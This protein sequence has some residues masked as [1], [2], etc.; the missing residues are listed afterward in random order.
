MAT[1]GEHPTSSR[2]WIPTRFYRTISEFDDN[3]APEY[4]ANYTAYDVFCLR[5]C[6][7]SYTNTYPE[8]NSFRQG[9]KMVLYVDIPQEFAQLV[10]VL[11]GNGEPMLVLADSDISID[12]LPN[13]WIAT[14]LPYVILDEN[15]DASVLTTTTEGTSRKYRSSLSLGILDEPNDSKTRLFVDLSTADNYMET[16]R[17]LLVSVTNQLRT[18]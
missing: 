1:I 9:N 4:Y 5:T 17:N 15:P 8:F 18:M 12:S 13:S 2:N 16:Y 3:T 7:A 14:M 11:S 6:L 10:D